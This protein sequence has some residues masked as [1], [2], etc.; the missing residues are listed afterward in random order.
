MLE[1]LMPLAARV[2][3][4]LKARGQTVAVADGAT[5]GLISAGLLAIAGATG[6]YMGGGVIY[7]LKGRDVLL[8]LEPEALKGMRSVTEPYA[9]LQARAIRD[10]FGADWGVAESGSAGPGK[11]PFGAEAGMSAIAVAGPGVELSRIVRTGQADRA[12]NMQ[13][14]ALAAIG[15]LDEALRS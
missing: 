6:F 15:L 8:D 10:R 11:H 12:G 9:L 5:G 13:S 14:F 7:S 2:A 4:T 3:E 1:E